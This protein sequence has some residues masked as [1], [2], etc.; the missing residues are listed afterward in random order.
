MVFDGVVAINELG[1][2]RIGCQENSVG[3]RLID[4]ILRQ[5]S[6]D[7]NFVVRVTLVLFGD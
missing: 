4:V 3:F 1:G 5:V 7:Q 2:V 6:G